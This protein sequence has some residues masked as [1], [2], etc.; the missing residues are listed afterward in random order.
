MTT[1]DDSVRESAEAALAEIAALVRKA[2]HDPD[3]SAAMRDEITA[4]GEAVASLTQQLAAQGH[5]CCHHHSCW[6]HYNVTYINDTLRI[7]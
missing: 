3:P 6:P 2:G 1:P 5:G 7:N 4:L